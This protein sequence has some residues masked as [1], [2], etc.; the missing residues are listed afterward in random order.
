MSTGSSSTVHKTPYTSPDA[1][2]LITEEAP[3]TALIQRMGRGNRKS[4]VP[5]TVGDIYVYPPDDP[6]KP[7][8]PEDLTGVPA[9]LAELDGKTVGQTD[10]EEA[11]KQYGRKP[12][13]GDRPVQ[14][15][16]SGPYANGDEEDFHD[17]DDFVE[18]GILS[19]PEYVQAPRLR[20]PG[21]IVPVPRHL[22]ERR[23]TQRDTRY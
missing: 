11:L 15:I 5:E 13:Q 4:V 23:G 21:L 3:I 17:I 19:E 20:R 7:Y 10:V 8:T 6:K 2:V 18:Q 9:F 14:F 16:I 1:D 12:P 22:E